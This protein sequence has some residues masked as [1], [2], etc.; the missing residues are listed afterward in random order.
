MVAG[1]SRRDWDCWYGKPAAISREAPIKEVGLME[2]RFQP[3]PLR[4]RSRLAALRD[5]IVLHKGHT[6]QVSDPYRSRAR[7]VRQ[8]AGFQKCLLLRKKFAVT[9]ADESLIF[10]KKIPLF[11]ILGNLPAKSFD[12]PEPENPPG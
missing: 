12:S 7:Q 9:R 2:L 4:A 1:D 11:V 6:A 10:Q 3:D 5:T 8:K